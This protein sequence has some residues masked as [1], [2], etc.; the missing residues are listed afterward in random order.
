MSECE[1]IWIELLGK[2]LEIVIGIVYRYPQYNMDE[3]SRSISETITKIAKN[4]RQGGVQSTLFCIFDHCYSI[5][6]P[7]K[8]KI[9]HTIKQLYLHNIMPKHENNAFQKKFYNE[10][11]KSTFSIECAPCL[12][13]TRHEHG[14]HLTAQ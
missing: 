14:V 7:N 9:C 12:G 5:S 3:F 2:R 13:H 4:S 11:K 8:L 1:N 10:F 6:S